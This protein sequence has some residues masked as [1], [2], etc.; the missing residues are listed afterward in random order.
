MDKWLKTWPHSFS[1]PTWIVANK[2]RQKRNESLQNG[3]GKQEIPPLGTLQSKR[4]NNNKWMNSVFRLGY[5]TWNL[6]SESWRCWF[7]CF[8]PH[9]DNH[10]PDSYFIKK[11]RTLVLMVLL[12][13]KFT[14]KQN[15]LRSLFRDRVF[16]F[17]SRNKKKLLYKQR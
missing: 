9:P 11:G 17:L 15:C 2:F 8:C 16:F 6:I 14:F 4:Q 10:F 7:E 13:I 12:F 3:N 5:L 1:W